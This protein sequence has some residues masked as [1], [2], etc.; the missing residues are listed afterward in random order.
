MNAKKESKEKHETTSWEDLVCDQ[1][2][3]EWDKGK[4]YVS[5]LNDLFDDIYAMFRGERP[6]KNYDWQS[7]VVVNKTFQ[8]V[9][10]AVPYLVSKIFGGSPIIGIKSFD[11]KGAW[12]REQILEFWNK[13]QGVKN[14][15]HI[16]YF[17]IIVSM[18]IRN[19]LNGMCIMK[20]TWNQKI[21]T[22]NGKRIA[23]EDYP[24]NIVLN[25]RDVVWDWALSPE[26]SIRQG[27]F[28]IHRSIEDLGSLYASGLYKN[29][30]QINLEQNPEKETASASSKDGQDSNPTSDIYTDVEKYERVGLW[31][32][33]REDGE[34]VPILTKGGYEDKTVKSKYMIAVVARGGVDTK[35]VL[36]RFEPSPYDEINYIDGKCYLDTERFNSQGMVE[37]T[38]DTITAMN[39]IFNGTLDAMWQNLMPPT[40]VNSAALWD[41]DTMVYAPQQRWILSG[42]PHS[43]VQFV[44]PPNVAR[45]AWQ[46]YGILDNE[47]QQMAITNAMAGAGKEKTATTNVMNAQLSAGKLDFI[48]HMI[49]NTILIPS[50]Q[51]DIRFAKKFAK[52]QT[53]DLIVTMA[54]I[55]QGIKPESFQFSEWEEIYQYVPAASGVKVEAQ[56]EKETQ[57]DIQMLQMLGAV[58]NP[59]T[60]K[61]INKILANIFRNRDMPVE[62]ELLDEDYFEPQGDAANMQQIMKNFGGASN[63][64]GIPMSQQEQSVRKIINT[65]R[66]M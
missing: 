9:W 34:W 62:S 10:T 60:P 24:Q 17:L 66:G 46:S 8:I 55:K 1:V 41:W 50:A 12:Q 51:M 43:S 11:K 56:K 20:K 64:Q 53:L 54:S 19:V 25:N 45:D 22:V 18:L 14:S 48:V 32:V 4:S 57:E 28:V 49:E 30:D 65:P 39:D 44:N 7:N 6:E 21:E 3:T 27:R 37:P 31:N 29:L 42:D 33:Y 36:I 47:A 58:N 5:D 23:V 16:P 63:E 26:Q 59:N 52:Q 61:I 38:K 15:D 13:L 2:L 40:V 35:D